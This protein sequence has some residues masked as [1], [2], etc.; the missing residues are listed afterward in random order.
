[1]RHVGAF[2]AKTHLSALLD[3]VERGE[4]VVITRHGV[5]VAKLSPAGGLDEERQARARAAIQRMAELRPLLPKLTI[6]EIIE[7]KNEGRK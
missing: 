2:E 7:Y 3:A 6:D 1:M 4:T 5:P